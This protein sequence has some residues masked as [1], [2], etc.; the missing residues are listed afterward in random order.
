MQGNDALPPRPEGSDD[1][2]QLFT[3]RL[4]LPTPAIYAVLAVIVWALAV[5]LGI[6]ASAAPPPV[7]ADAQGDQVS[8]ERAFAT[9]QR[10]A[11][12]SDGQ[13]SDPRPVGSEANAACRQRIQEELRRLGLDPSVQEAFG[14]Y[15]RHR[16]AG[17]VRN[18]VARLRGTGELSGDGQAILC[19][20]HYDSVP[21]G[22]GIGDDLAGV[23]AWIEVARALRALRPLRRDVIFLFED[24]EEQGLLGAEVFA[25]QHPWSKDVGAV[26]NLEGRGTHGPSRLF[27]TGA[28]NAWIVKAFA[29]E[30]TAPSASSISTEIYRRMPNDTDYTVW[31]ERGIP[32]LN[33]AFIGGASSYHTPLDDLGS[34]SKASLQH[35]VQNGLDAVRAL[36][37]VQ[38]PGPDYSPRGDAVFFEWPWVGLVAFGYSTGRALSVM[39]LLI[40]FLAAALWIRRRE[41]R[42][43][44]VIGAAAFLAILVIGSVAAGHGARLALEALGVAAIEHAARPSFIVCATLGGAMATFLAIALA[45]GRFFHAAE[46]AV[47]AVILLG[48]GSLALGFSITGGVYL[49]LVPS[50]ALAVSMCLLGWMRDRT[51]ATCISA[52]VAIG[53]TGILWGPLHLALVDAFGSGSGAIVTAPIA[54]AAVLLAIPVAGRS[55]SVPWLGLCAALVGTASGGLAAYFPV[56]SSLFPAHVDIVLSSEAGQSHVLLRGS[57]AAKAWFRRDTAGDFEREDFGGE[58]GGKTQLEILDSGTRAGGA[59]YV[60]VRVTAQI[61]SDMLRVAAIGAESLSVDGSPGLVSGTYILGPNP[62]G[63]ELVL[64]MSQDGPLMISTHDYCYGLDEPRFDRFVGRWLKSRPNDT[65]PSQDGDRYQLVTRWEVRNGSVLG[66]VGARGR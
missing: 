48:I 32:G 35:H 44:G 23:A 66:A 42:A 53:F 36:G 10:L 30:A 15:P 49:V 61:G 28:D 19:M 4:L 64:D 54:I 14:S 38:I 22:P 60:R 59:P 37:R 62:E 7:A 16:A 20:A 57:S 18:I 27:E 1:P 45:I 12:G 8:G 26:L 24:G 29:E 46:V 2:G 51:H 33:F 40:S 9:L 3:E 41:V 11:S 58:G 5:A 65:V 39:A 31:R 34:L 52:I 13:I 21:A 63:H 47:T 43:R 50:L 55:A 25:A 6:L 56:Y 17:T